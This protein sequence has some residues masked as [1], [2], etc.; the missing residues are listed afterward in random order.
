MAPLKS[1]KLPVLELIVAGA[2]Y[3]ATN[4][5]VAL[6]RA[7]SRY[8]MTCL[9]LCGINQDYYRVLLHII[10]DDFDPV[11]RAESDLISCKVSVNQDQRCP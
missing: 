10:T 4:I 3:P 8:G 2:E 11:I 7:E 1:L 5:V 6:T 9:I